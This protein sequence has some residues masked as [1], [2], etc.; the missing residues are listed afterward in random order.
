MHIRKGQPVSFY[1]SL[2]LLLTR[3][4][5][6]HFRGKMGLEMLS[7]LPAEAMKSFNNLQSS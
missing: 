6:Q 5:E 7:A 2:N 4:A 1:T 3:Q